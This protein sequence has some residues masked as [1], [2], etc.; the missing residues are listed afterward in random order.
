MP[1]KWNSSARDIVLVNLCHRVPYTKRL[2]THN[3]ES[4][5]TCTSVLKRVRLGGYKRNKMFQDSVSQFCNDE[6]P[7]NPAATFV[8]SQS[9]A[10]IVLIIV[11]VL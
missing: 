7:K 6:I 1:M 4:E 8:R 2:P 5:N 9:L 11:N 3:T 10:C